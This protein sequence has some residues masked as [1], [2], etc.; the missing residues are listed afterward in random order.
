MAPLL[1]RLGFSIDVEMLRPGYV[2]RGGGL[3]R[4][5]AEP[6]R[7]PLAPLVLTEA[8][9]LQRLWGVALSSHLA[10]RRVSD[11]MAAAA[12]SVLAAA[13]HDCEIE[14]QDD[15][16]ALQ[17]G[18]AIALFAD[19]QGAARLGADRAGAPRRPAEAVGAYAAYYLLEDMAT[20]ATLDRYAADQVILFAA[21]AAGQSRFTIPDVTEHVTTSGWL[22]EQLLGSRV[23]AE[24]R[25]LV[26]DGVGFQRQRAE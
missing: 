8:G 25:S 6:V 14:L 20:A 4:L 19:Y 15:T 22:V 2:P 5:R 16:S 12:K 17:R 11:R 10:E 26:I 7:V 21:L 1:R 3:L 13:G 23:V 24:G 18:A 9:P